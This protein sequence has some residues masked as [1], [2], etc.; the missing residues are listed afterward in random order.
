MMMM[1][2]RVL[3]VPSHLTDRFTLLLLLTLFFCVPL[4]L[5]AECARED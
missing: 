2:F 3:V 4:E 1:L 5:G